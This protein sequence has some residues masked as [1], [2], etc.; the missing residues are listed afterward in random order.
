MKSV[1]L[2]LTLILT[3]VCLAQTTCYTD[4]QGTTLCSHPDTVING[5]TSSIGQSV[6][7][8]DRGNRLDYGVDQFGQATVRLPAGKTIDWSQSVP[9][10]PK[11]PPVNLVRPLPGSPV[12]PVVPGISL[13]L[14]ATR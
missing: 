8:D 3:P 4:K 11:Q 12:Q 9:V 6:Y 2:F 10:E 13:P 5:N 7:R 14:G 1:A